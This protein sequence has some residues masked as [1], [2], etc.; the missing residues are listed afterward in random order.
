M[1]VMEEAIS[2]YEFD[3]DSVFDVNDY[4]YFYQD[5]LTDERSQ[6]EVDSLVK[7]IRLDRQMKILDLACGFGRHTNRFAMLGH[8]VIGVDIYSDFLDIARREAEVENLKVEYIQ[9]DMRKIK[10]FSEFD[11]VLM[12]F[13]AFG[14]FDDE[15]NFVVLKNVYSALKPD[16]LFVFDIPNRDVF[17]KYIQSYIVTEVGEDLMIDRISF[18]PIA[19]RTLNRRI[20]IRDGVRK[21]KPFSLRLY[22]A[23][24]IVDLLQAAN[25]KDYRFYST[26]EGESLDNDSRRLIV[27]T[28]K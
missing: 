8:E 9:A 11:R 25:F 6:A 12:L 5:S 28:E 10:Y 27:V 16:G 26:W 1:N 24:E 7:L 17:L 14:Y 4:L 22:N 23:N 20:V 18:N 13:T 2:S 15:T 3:F 21:E 19:E